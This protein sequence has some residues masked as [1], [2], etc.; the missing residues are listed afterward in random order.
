MLQLLSYPSQYKHKVK[1]KFIENQNA[2]LI[3]YLIVSLSVDLLILS[4][5]LFLSE[6][7]FE[8]KLSALLSIESYFFFSE[9]FF[10]DL[11]S[12]YYPYNSRSYLF[13]NSYL[14]FFN[15]SSYSLSFLASSSFAYLSFY[16]FSTIYYFNYSAI[17]IY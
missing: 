1:K 12:S 15:L 7:L 13:Y 6:D 2:N 17:S 14:S 3:T 8:T 10:S 5:D 4:A 11:I 9:V 16:F